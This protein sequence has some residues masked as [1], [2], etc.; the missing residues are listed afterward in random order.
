[1]NNNELPKWE[2][3][4]QTVGGFWSGV[5]AEELE[6]TLNEWG[7]QGWE[8]VSTHILEN[9]NKVNVIAKRPLTRETIRLR[10][11]PQYTY[12]KG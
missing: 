8:V 6:R 9:Q 3:R 5:K 11:M 1:M 4:V 12:E 2:Y 7:E 10:S